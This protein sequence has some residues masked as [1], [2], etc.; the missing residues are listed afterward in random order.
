ML[1]GEVPRCSYCQGVLKPN[2][3]FYGEGMNEVQ[4]Q[5][6]EA[7]FRSADLVLVLGSSLSVFPASSLPLLTVR[8]G[9]KM[10][11]VNASPTTYDDEAI[12]RLPDLEKA[13]GDFV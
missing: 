11:I 13:F 6:A 4:I 5:R 2:V 10:I 12:L 9:G 1:A 8:L 7:D 3:I